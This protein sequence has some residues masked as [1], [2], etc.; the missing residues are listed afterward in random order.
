MFKMM[1][2]STPVH[3]FGYVVEYFLPSA[4]VSIPL[5]EQDD[6]VL[7]IIMCILYLSEFASKQYRCIFKCS[8]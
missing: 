1:L 3:R 2:K 5:Q 6:F 4:L 7:I 8:I